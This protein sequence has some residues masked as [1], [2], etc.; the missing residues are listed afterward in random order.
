M[1]L[2][3]TLNFCKLYRFGKSL[4]S[5]MA[6]L[7]AWKPADLL[8]YAVPVFENHRQ[9]WSHPKQAEAGVSGYGL[10]WKRAYWAYFRENDHFRTQNWLYKFGQGSFHFLLQ[11]E[12]IGLV[13]SKTSWKWAE[14]EL[15]LWSAFIS[16]R[17]RSFSE[18]SIFSLFSIWKRSLYKFGHCARIYRPCFGCENQQFCENQLCITASGS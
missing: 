13:R 12:G 11:N 5:N 1:S 18:M 15:C 6:A 9:V 14:N 2:W 3:T 10:N 16:W 7:W 8:L 17:K 4:P